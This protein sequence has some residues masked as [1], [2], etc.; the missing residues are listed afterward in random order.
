MTL[1]RAHKVH[2]SDR[3]RRTGRDSVGWQLSHLLGFCPV[4]DPAAGSAA[5]AGSP[6][7]TSGTEDMDHGTC[8]GKEERGATMA[9]DWCKE[10]KRSFVR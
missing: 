7:K 5:P 1:K 3:E 6:S 8:I 10:E 4:R 2:S 9:R